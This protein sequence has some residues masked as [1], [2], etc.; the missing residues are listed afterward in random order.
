MAAVCPENTQTAAVIRF[1]SGV[2]K[3][4]TSMEMRFFLRERGRVAPS[5]FAAIGQRSHLSGRRSLTPGVYIL[6]SDIS[7]CLTVTPKTAA[8]L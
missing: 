8:L 1:S 4:L 2:S 6:L 7:L 3:S 5:L